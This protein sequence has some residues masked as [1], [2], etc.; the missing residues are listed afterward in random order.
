MLPLGTLTACP[1]TVSCIS[2]S[3]SGMLYLLQDTRWQIWFDRDL[4]C[5]SEHLRGK[6]AG[7]AERGGD[8]ETFMPCSQP[9]TRSR[10]MGADQRQ[11]IG[12]SSAQTCPGTNA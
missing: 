7:C 9:Y 12:R 1:F 8:A 3:L 10:G 11:S 6:Q 4:R 2:Y 5:A